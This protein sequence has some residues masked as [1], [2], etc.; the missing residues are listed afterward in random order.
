MRRLIHTKLIVS[1]ATKTPR[2]RLAGVALAFLLALLFI[3]TFIT[4]VNPSLFFGFV[5]ANGVLQSCI[6]SYFQTALVA[7]ASWFGHQAI[8][9]MFS[10]QAAVAVIISLLQLLSALESLRRADTAIPDSSITPFTERS[11]VDRAAS[12]SFLV[13]TAGMLLALL[14]HAYLTRMTIYKEA[15]AEFEGRLS[16]TTATEETPLLYDQRQGST[17]TSE[18]L[19]QA[20]R[21]L[22]VSQLILKD[23]ILDISQ[24][25][26]INWTYNLA[27]FL[28]FFVTLVCMGIYRS[29]F[30]R[31]I[32]VQAVFPAITLAITS[33]RPPDSSPVSHPLVFTAVHF[34]LFNLGDWVGRWLCKFSSLQIWSGEKLLLLSF[35]R[36]VFVPI[37]LACNLQ[38]AIFDHPVFNSDTAF[39]TILFL[40]GLT[41]GQLG[42]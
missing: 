24:I 2:I 10:G 22:R 36:L 11:T 39:L 33:V 23:A 29:P 38:P 31:L 17:S 41:G 9:S 20:K 30:S 5:I 40:F 21:I 4:G 37:F 13:M 12:T 1:Q 34:L 32:T 35:L 16:P 42:R 15:V 19:S 14:S 27:I 6:N 26:R 25:L 28:L 8:R 18:D 7:I 3:S